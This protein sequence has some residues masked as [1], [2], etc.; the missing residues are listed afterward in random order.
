[1]RDLIGRLRAALTSQSIAILLLAALLVIGFLR[2]GESDAD[3]LERRTSRALSAVAGA[4]RVEVVIH[5]R[6]VGAQG[7]AL[8]TS[9]T[10]QIPCGAVAIAKGA[11]DPV[12][13][14]QLQDALC[15]LLSLPASSVSI[16]A[17]GD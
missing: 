17:G 12:V 4:G 3:A 16:I 13:R 15:A 5:T 8:G 10:Q 11:N 7:A 6:P 14:V 1:M 9:P 2:G